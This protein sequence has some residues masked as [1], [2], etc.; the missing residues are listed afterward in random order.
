MQFTYISEEKV[1]IYL[2]FYM[3]AS[4]DPLINRLVAFFN[5]PFCHVEMAFPER[6]GIEPWEKEMWGS[7][8]NQGDC[9][10]YKCKTYQREGYYSFAI[11]VTKAQCLKI[12]NYCRS[13]SDKKVMFNKL[14]MY[15]AYLPIQIFDIEGTFCSKHVV[16]ALQA[17]EVIEVMHLNPCLVTPSS[18]YKTLMQSK[19]NTSIVQIVPSKMSSV[20]NNDNKNQNSK[21]MLLCTKMA[22]EMIT[23]LRTTN[24][25]DKNTNKCEEVIDDGNKSKPLFLYTK[26]ASDMI[27][28]LKN[29]TCDVVETKQHENK[30]LQNNLSFYFVNSYLMNPSKNKVLDFS[31]RIQE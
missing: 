24:V 10:F 22:T 13:Q 3:P 29:K 14:A 1:Q 19:S 8:I 16:M 25:T 4:D 2:L 15:S 12:K 5:G 9:I 20:D 28:N 30:T 26:M 31:I 18:L 17:G 21:N 11:E 23:K 27:Y 7:S 6:Y